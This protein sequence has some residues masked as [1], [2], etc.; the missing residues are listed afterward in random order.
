MENIPCV[1]VFDPKGEPSLVSARWERWGKSFNIYLVALGDV[2]GAR[3]KAL[4]LHCGG[5]EL[6]EIFET[7]EFAGDDVTPDNC[8]YAQALEALNKHF[9]AQRNDTFERNVF[10]QMAQKEGEATA[11]FITRLR[12]QAKHCNFGPTLGENI[13]DQV[14]DKCA[15]K[16]LKAKLL[17]RMNL[18][19]PVLMQISQAHEAA[20]GFV[21]QMT[22]ST[23]T[24]AA[25][26]QLVGAV[27][28]RSSSKY[29][30]ERQTRAS[31][32]KVEK[33]K[34]ACFRCGQNTHH[35]K[36]PTCPAMGKTCRLAVPKTEPFR[37]CV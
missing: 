37:C 18:T 35:A 8:S 11:Q 3:K 12:Q 17:E 4:L 15:D 32:H 7:F 27:G 21:R 29:V 2:A 25:D 16:R 22:P 20:S 14:I 6:Q 26:S 28:G 5:S 19:L 23:S 9:G 30:K 24:D 10:R 13:R 34:G 31:R 36:D 1:S 33:K